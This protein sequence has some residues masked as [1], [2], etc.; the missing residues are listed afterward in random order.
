MPVTSASGRSGFLLPALCLLFF[1]S[2]ACALVYQVLWL[3]TLGWV[4]GVTV[5]AASA[6]WAMFMAGLA[7][8][9]GAAGLVADRVRNP[10]RWFGATELLIGATAL[11]TPTALARLQQ[12]YVAAYPSISHSP[13]GLVAVHLAMAFAVLIVPTSRR[14]RSGAARSAASW[15]RS[16]PAMRQARSWAP[17][18]PVST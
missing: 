16:M 7:L 11:V 1:C 6:V 18:R 9:S 2:G 14:P 10:L 15:D 3:R 17:L 4:F 8:G 12:L 13:A 5:Y